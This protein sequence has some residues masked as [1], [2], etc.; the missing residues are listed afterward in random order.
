MCGI[1]QMTNGI[2]VIDKPENMSSAKVVSLVKKI[3]GAKKAG[4]TG[5]LDP[6]ATGVMVCCLNKATRLS[7]FFLNSDK[8]Y[9]GT[10][11]LGIETDTQDCTGTILSKSDNVNFSPETLE[12]AFQKFTGPIKQIP[13]VYSALKH[14]GVPLYKLARKGKPVQKPPRDVMI[15]RLEILD[16]NLPEVSFSVSCSSGTYIRTLAADI[17]RK[18]GCGAFL[19][20]LRRT[21]CGHFTLK[22]AITLEE[23][24]QLARSGS[25]EKR[26]IPMADAL[27]HMPYY[28]AD[29]PLTE[30]I[31]YGNIITGSD[32]QA[33][34]E[35]GDCIR[36]I[37]SKSRLIAVLSKKESDKYNYCCVFIN[38]EQ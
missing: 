23:L 32:I 37:D 35:P 22:N 9:E 12:A 28:I 8:T 11:C 29:H 34:L 18:L 17:G 19:K 36:I 30:K 5:T 24:E 15:S 33:E 16:I 10:L 6:F 21:G 4:H 2:L 1:Q 31:R 20:T 25:I 3:S 26:I 7:G 14:K 27:P 13:P 38:S